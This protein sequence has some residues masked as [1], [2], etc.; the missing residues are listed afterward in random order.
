MLINHLITEI[1]V[2]EEE[3][4]EQAISMIEGK[5]LVKENDYAVLDNGTN[6]LRYY[7]RQNNRWVLDETYNNLPIDEIKFFSH[8]FLIYLREIR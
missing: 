8:V 2:P 7:K 4:S 3:A 1:D 5:K 6:Q